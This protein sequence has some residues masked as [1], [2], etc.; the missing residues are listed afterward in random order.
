M[1]TQET[2]PSRYRGAFNTVWQC[3]EPAGHPRLHQHSQPASGGPITIRWNEEQAIET[4][5]AMAS[6]TIPRALLEALTDAAEARDQT[7]EDVEA[8]AAARAFLDRN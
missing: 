6:V 8:V 1:N 4:L 7:E 3:Q 2:C 5:E